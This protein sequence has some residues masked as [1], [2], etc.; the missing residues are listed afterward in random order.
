MI[1]AAPF[2]TEP[3]PTAP[4]LIDRATGAAK[5]AAYACRSDAARR[6]FEY[7]IAHIAEAWL[8]ESGQPA[9]T[10]ARLSDDLRRVLALFDS[11]A[12]RQRECQ[13]PREARLP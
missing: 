1:A 6:H 5:A 4:G 11:L 2:H 9:R 3:P 13:A 10:P 8:A 12:A 7:A